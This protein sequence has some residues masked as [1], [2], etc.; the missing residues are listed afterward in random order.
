MTLGEKIATQRKKNNYTQEQLAEIL[1]VSRQSVSKWESDIAYPETDKLIRLG[2]L[3]DCSMDYLLKDT[4]ADPA[5]KEKEE[6][7]GLGLFTYPA[8]FD[9]FERKSE[10]MLLGMPLY[11]IG[12]NARGFFAV[13]LK[14]TGVFSLGFASSGIFSFGIASLGVISFGA[15]SLGIIALGALSAGLIS[16]GAIALGFLAIGGVSIGFFSLGAAAKGYYIAVG[17]HANA[18]IAIGKTVATGSLYR[19][20]GR[21]SSSDTD[22]VRSLLEQ[23]AHPLLR[24]AMKLFLL[25]LS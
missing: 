6:S 12:K 9:K 11:H 7:S 10:K 14:A 18:R 16:I 17:D 21:I 15:A 1:S 25:F 2:K 3:F 24:W 19:H 4:V 8:F 22:T 20:L 13:G 23:Q 5:G